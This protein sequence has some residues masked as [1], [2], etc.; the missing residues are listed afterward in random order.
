MLES[1]VDFRDFSGRLFELSSVLGPSSLLSECRRVLEEEEVAFLE[2][3]ASLNELSHFLVARLDF[4]EASIRS[5]G[6]NDVD[7]E[8]VYSSNQ[9]K[10]RTSLLLRLL[11]LSRYQ[12]GE[13]IVPLH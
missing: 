8:I 5:F 7:A 3:G 6:S 12:L 13:V 10:I 1:V 11:A 4:V 9:T 2:V